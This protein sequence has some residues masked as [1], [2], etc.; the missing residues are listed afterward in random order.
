MT[1]VSISGADVL[2]TSGTATSAKSLVKGLALVDVVAGASRPHS[3]AEIIERTGLPRA[4]ALR[5]LE[6][7]CRTNVLRT[8]GSGAYTLGPRVVRW[9]Q[10]FLDHIDMRSQGLDLM[11]QLV[12]ITDETCFLGV[13]D[14]DQ[15]LYVAAISSPQPVR[16]GADVGFRNPLHSTGVGKA[17][18]AGMPDDELRRLLPERLERRTPNTMTSRA[19]LLADLAEI[20]RRGYAVDD[21]ENEDGVR[22]VAAPVRDHTG[23]V[24]GALSVSAPAYRFSAEDVHRL[25][26]HILRVTQELSARLGYEPR[27]VDGRAP[28]PVEPVTEGSAP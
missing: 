8:D 21:V 5:L 20:R 13:R 6:V 22:C 17:L 23:A 25:A 28:T 4:T 14:G 10:S 15:V 18:L 3:A 2:S 7:L 1:A 12:D 16:P 9:G 26:P 11:E 27:T 19:E 24:C